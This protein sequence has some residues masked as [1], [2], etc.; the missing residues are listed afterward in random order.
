MRVPG[1]KQQVESVRLPG[2][3]GP[4]LMSPDYGQANALRQGLAGIGNELESAPKMAN[5]AAGG[6]L[7]DLR[8]RQSV[9]DAAA[10]EASSMAE[11]GSTL[12]FNRR[13][14]ARLN[15]DSAAGTQGFLSLQG[16]DASE[17]SAKVLADFEKDRSEVAEATSDIDARQRFLLRSGE[18][19]LAYRK[20]VES[21]VGK[22][23]GAAKAAT[24]KGLEQQS[25]G[26][27][28]SGIAD[29]DTYATLTR[30]TE[31][32]LRENVPGPVGDAAVA[33]FRSKTAEAFIGGKLASGDVE[34]AMRLV[35]TQRAEL[36]GRYIEVKR[37][38][39][40]AAVGRKKDLA[41]AAVTKQVEEWA[42]SA[43][44]KDSYI[45]EKDLRAKAGAVGGRGIQVPEEQREAFEA[46]IA[47]KMK[48][49]SARLKA[50]IAEHQKVA[51]RADLE[52]LPTPGASVA[53]LAEYDPHFLRGLRAQRR[54]RILSDRVARDGSAS[55]QAELRRQQAALDLEAQRLFA[56][57]LYENPEADP[58]EFTRKFV[59]DYAAQGRDVYVSAPASALLKLDRA[60]AESGADKT[61]ATTAKTVGATLEKTIRDGTPKKKGQPIDEPT[62][63]ARVGAGMLRY[64][65]MVEENGGKPLSTEQLGELNA[66]ALRSSQVEVPGRVY[67]T[68]TINRLNVDM[69]VLGPPAPPK[70]PV[71]A[72]PT[73]TGKNG[74][75]FRL[76]EDGKTWEPIK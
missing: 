59:A 7:K 60:K 28:E 39:D 29:L 73:A 34:G 62:L 44:N 71:K 30:Q 63:K 8:A 58:E 13:I 67:G 32:L 6:D 66:W 51:E 38:V 10:K 61:E 4:R 5:A 49:E 1:Y 24:L 18:A 26:M 16:L 42:L 45:S 76:S 46:A 27:A 65:A 19:L 72:R 21:H 70:A 54:A 53:F 40:R 56:T 11:A 35:E 69:P 57:E 14:Q 55:Q 47:K 23:F 17:Q 74:Q 48:V 3:G 68:R 41:D 37:E 15:G 52:D 33:E 50:D 31:Q 25:I 9:V 12:E 22:E 75:K 36:A 20:Q 2:Q 64:R 43:R